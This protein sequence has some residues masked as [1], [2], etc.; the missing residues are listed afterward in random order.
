MID[1]LVRTGIAR[2]EFV[3]FLGHGQPS[4]FS[5]VATE[6]AG[7]QGAWWEFHDH[8]MTTRDFS[9][10]GADA[11]AASLNL[12]TDA[13]G[14]CLDDQTHLDAVNAAH[15]SAREAGVNRTPTVRINGQGAATV[16]DRLI[17]QVQALAAELNDG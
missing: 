14:Q 5:A 1:E 12:D 6:C 16:G 9:R 17:E 4:L 13:F 15:A 2:F 8:Y 7:D 3:H 11:L 10:E